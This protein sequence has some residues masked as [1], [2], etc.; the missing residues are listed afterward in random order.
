MTRVGIIGAGGYAAAE[1]IR[2]LLG[3]PAVRITALA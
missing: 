1:L 2:L 3:H